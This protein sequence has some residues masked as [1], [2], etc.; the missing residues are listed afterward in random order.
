MT[1]SANS[2]R[3]ELFADLDG[4]ATADRAR[5]HDGERRQAGAA[6]VPVP[7]PQCPNVRR[8]LVRKR[9][10]EILRRASL[11]D[12]P[13][14]AP[15][16]VVRWRME[17]DARWFNRHRVRGPKIARD[18]ERI[19]SERRR[20]HRSE[21]QPNENNNARCARHPTLQAH[22]HDAPGYQSCYAGHGHGGASAPS[23]GPDAREDIGT[24]VTRK[25]ES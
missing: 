1:A 6:R 25:I 23:T 9:H 12:V 8:A 17:V 20:R 18:W 2:W 13:L 15:S 21:R 16:V 14:G 19:L 10:P 11:R 7:W 24:K 3:A 4:H 22:S 5:Q